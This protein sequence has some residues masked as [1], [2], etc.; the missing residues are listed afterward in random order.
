MVLTYYQKPTDDHWIQ[1]IF[2]ADCEGDSVKSIVF[3][4]EVSYADS[5]KPSLK[6]P[7]GEFDK[8]AKAATGKLRAFEY[9]T[10]VPTCNVFD[11]VVTSVHISL[12]PTRFP[13]H[14]AGRVLGLGHPSEGE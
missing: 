13:C 7:A 14:D 11:C 6:I 9:C 8:A 12:C 4:R 2:V 10:K 1:H 3:H 5:D